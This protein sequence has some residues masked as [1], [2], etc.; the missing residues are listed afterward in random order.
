[1]SMCCQ[2][3]GKMTGEGQIAALLVWLRRYGGSQRIGWV[4]KHSCPTL[5]RQGTLSLTKAPIG[6]A[7]R[8]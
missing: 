2:P 6:A 7:C 4:G 8:P 3:H 5:H 1:M